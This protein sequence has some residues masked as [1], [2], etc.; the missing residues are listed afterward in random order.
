MGGR[1]KGFKQTLIFLAGAF[2]VFLAASLFL[3]EAGIA[4]LYPFAVRGQLEE[5]SPSGNSYTVYHGARSAVATA[6]VIVVG[7]DPEIAQSYDVLGHFMRF[8]KQYSE[9]GAVVLAV[10]DEGAEEINLLL[11]SESGGIQKG[12]AALLQNMPR[13]SVDFVDFV[14]EL[15]YVNATMTPARKFI[16]MSY[17]DG[18]GAVLSEKLIEAH[19]YATE[20]HQTCFVVADVELLCDGSLSASLEEMFGDDVLILKTRYSGKDYEGPSALSL[21]FMGSVP[22]EYFVSEKHL[23]GYNRYANS[24]LNFFRDGENTNYAEKISGVDSNGFFFVISN[25]TPAIYETTEVES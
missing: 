25:G 5:I 19:D 7:I 24:T 13:L 8:A 2:V 23:L 12:R 9:I 6:D 11:S 18:E 22:K 16:A 15:A 20:K 1:K 3:T 14:T 21:P 17:T 4:R 10:D